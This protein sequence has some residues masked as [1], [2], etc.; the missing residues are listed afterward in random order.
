[1]F[2]MLKIQKIPGAAPLNPPKTYSALQTTQLL[3][4]RTLRDQNPLYKVQIFSGIFRLFSGK[5]CTAPLKICG[6]FA[7][8]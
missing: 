8:G 4:A 1:M 7:Y 3:I 2:K 5:T 6:P